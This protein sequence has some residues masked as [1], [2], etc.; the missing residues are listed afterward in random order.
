MNA[1]AFD[2]TLTTEQ[3]QQLLE[4]VHEYQEVNKKYLIKPQSDKQPTTPMIVT[5]ENTSY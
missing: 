3:T 1:P 4:K 2:E 5:M